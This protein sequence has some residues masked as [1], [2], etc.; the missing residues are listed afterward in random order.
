[1]AILSSLSTFSFKYISALAEFL[2]NSCILSADIGA[3]NGNSP[4]DG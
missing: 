2:C 3:Y 1:V 4:H